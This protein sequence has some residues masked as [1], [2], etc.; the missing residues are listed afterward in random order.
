MQKKVKMQKIV[1][2]DGISY[3]IE[4]HAYL[5]KRINSIIL[6]TEHLAQVSDKKKALNF[7]LVK[8]NSAR[9]ALQQGA[10]SNLINDFQLIKSFQTF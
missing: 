3:D 10:L 2:P 1:Y 4:K 8:Q 6:C 7:A 5:T 9:V